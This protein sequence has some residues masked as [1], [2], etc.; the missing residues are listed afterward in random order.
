MCLGV[1][2]EWRVEHRRGRGGG[3]LHVLR[4][5]GMRLTAGLE[6]CCEGRDLDVEQLSCLSSLL[7]K[8]AFKC[9]LSLAHCLRTGPNMLCRQSGMTILASGISSAWV[10]V[11]GQN[12]I[13]N[14]S[15]FHFILCT[16]VCPSSINLLLVDHGIQTSEL[17]VDMNVRREKVNDDDRALKESPAP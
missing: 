16:T 14:I 1:G 8:K 2:L 3:L 17:I 9:S 15:L 11:S 13:N 12:L 10:H 6:C 7:A 5:E 4:F